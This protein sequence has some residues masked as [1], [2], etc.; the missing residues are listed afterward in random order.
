[1]AI[2]LLTPRLRNTLL[3]RVTTR[4]TFALSLIVLVISS[5]IAILINPLDVVA[6]SPSNLN[7]IDS[8][9]YH[10]TPLV[11][12]TDSPSS[13]ATPAATSPLSISNQGEDDFT[14]Q[15]A[16]SLTR[17]T[18][19]ENLVNSKTYYDIS[20]R[21]A[22]AGVIKTVEMAFPPGTYV[23]A[24][25]LIEAVGIGPGTIAASGTTATGMTLTYTVTNE[26]NVPA[27]TRMRIQVANVNNPPDPS[28][29]LTVTITTRDSAN[30][31]IDGPTATNAYNIKQ[32]GTT[33]IANN[34]V[35]TSK[36]ADDSVTEAK[37]KED[38][39]HVVA[40]SAVTPKYLRTGGLFDP[41]QYDANPGLA[42][43][44]NSIA[45]SGLNVHLTFTG[46]GPT[47]SDIFYVRSTN[48]GGEFT[49]S[50]NLSNDAA[51]S[52]ISAVATSGNNVY[53]VWQNGPSGSEDIFYRRST[54][55]G[56]SFGAIENLSN[57][58][59]ESALPSIAASENNVYVIWRENMS[60][61]N[62]ILYRRSID[63]GANF[64]PAVNLS[65]NAG[66]SGLPSV[67]ISG[68]NVFVVWE[69]NTLGNNEILFRRSI[70]G[71]AN[72]EPA[73]NLSNNAGSSL[74]A[75][76]AASGNNV[77]VVWA[78]TT[79]GNSEIF[80]RRSA[81]N[82]VNFDSAINLSHDPAIPLIAESPAVA[83]KG[84]NVYV[85]WHARPVSMGVDQVYSI[86]ST[87]TGTDFGPTT[88]LIRLNN[89]P[90]VASR[91]PTI[92]IS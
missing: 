30:N 19:T 65:N 15:A 86:R 87:D 23:G 85:L 81:N 88:K 47:G 54:D 20:F 48:G 5:P 27:L 83:A 4:L 33:E 32:I 17:A 66:G 7:R 89:G 21:T 18:Q 51:T 67:V 63:G 11:P 45:A 8:S 73:V 58:A 91:N 37:I 56:N 35:T 62:E 22:T 10:S 39:V 42:G 46:T 29:S 53:V 14:T 61:N 52:T 36:I 71:G 69:D 16:L 3:L 74:F 9:S 70:D 34:A 80:F 2:G 55:G 28:N 24:A 38:L 1:M 84:S 78:D 77:Y 79:P 57:S 59:G 92:A 12:E 26:V 82:G 6:T 76:I 44:A 40:E 90:G 49:S 64:E 75:S 25:V 72:F 43:F 68:N 60:G 41:T 31:I 50:I 13:L